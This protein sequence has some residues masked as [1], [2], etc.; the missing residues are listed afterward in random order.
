MKKIITWLRILFKRQLKK[1]S[2]YVILAMLILTCAGIRY[3]AQNFSVHID[4]G[5]V[6]QDDG[7]VSSMIE[8]GLYEHNGLVSF[9][10]YDSRAELVSAVQSGNVYGGYII[11]PEFSKKLIEGDT[12]EIIEALST[13]NNIISGISNEM[14][15][16]FVM[17]EL[18]YEELVQD[19]IDTGLFDK[20]S[21]EEIRRELREYYDANLANGSTF[22]LAYENTPKDYEGKFTSI[23]ILDYISPVIAGLTGLMIFIG[24][25]CG[26]LSYYDDRKNGSLILLSPVFKQLTAI[27]EIAVP[28]F[29]ITA[30]GIFILMGTGM[31]T[32]AGAAIFK[33]IIYDL[34]VIAYCYLLKTIIRRKEMLVS[35]IP[36]LSLISI[37]FCPIFTNIASVSPFMANIGKAVPLYWLY[38]I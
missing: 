18:S 32:Q 25:L 2:L 24:G 10:K 27:I 21:E 28:V 29:I 34:I 7:N 4:I 14:F 1:V 23:D 15:F 9:V 17:K 16:S 30:A 26:C 13:P 38:Y 5:V 11:K 33:Y 19:T 22:S 20:L 37:L 12:E 36:V 8:K 6:N 3:V 35:L 31:E